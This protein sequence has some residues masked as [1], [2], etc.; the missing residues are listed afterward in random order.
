ML[1]EGTSFSGFNRSNSK[2]IWRSGRNSAFFVSRKLILNKHKIEDYERMLD[3][4][5]DAVVFLEPYL[6][7]D[8]YRRES[9]FYVGECVERA[10]YVLFTNK[11]YSEYPFPNSFGN[12]DVA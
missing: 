1:T 10:W 5:H 3:N 7:R 9:N 2:N 8:N 4:I 12:I 11:S 6:I